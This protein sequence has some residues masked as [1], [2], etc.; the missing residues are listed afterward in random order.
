MPHTLKK[1]RA[2]RYKPSLT[3]RKSRL[4]PIKEFNAKAMWKKIISLIKPKREKRGR[5]T[6]RP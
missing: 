4:S 2:A 6:F 1:Q 5:T 3:R